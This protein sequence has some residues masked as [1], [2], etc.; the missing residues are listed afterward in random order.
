[1][2]HCALLGSIERFLGVFVE[3]TAG[4]FPFWVGAR[5]GP[6]PDDQRLR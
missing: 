2:I 4:W 3:H 1:M 5:A 6:N